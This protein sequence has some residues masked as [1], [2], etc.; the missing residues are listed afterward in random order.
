MKRRHGGRDRLVAAEDRTVAAEPIPCDH[1]GF[2]R[3]IVDL[4]RANGVLQ[5]EVQTLKANL[6]TV[7]EM[8]DRW[9]KRARGASEKVT[10]LQVELR[11]LRE[12]SD[13]L[14]DRLVDVIERPQPTVQAAP[15]PDIVAL[16]TSIMQGI[17]PAPVAFPQDEASIRARGGIDWAAEGL[18]NS[19]GASP[20]D[21]PDVVLAVEDLNPRD[22]EGSTRGGWFNPGRTDNVNGSHAGL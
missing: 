10:D 14:V 21:L 17:N 9:E 15:G 13:R 16:V 5:I 18:D 6:T 3:R 12:H 11:T 22:F 4:E 2:L 19:G 8:G 7:G 1:T 20:A